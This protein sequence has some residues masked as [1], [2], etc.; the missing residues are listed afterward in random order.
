M[1]H[2]IPLVSGLDRV[3]TRYRHFG[4]FLASAIS[5]FFATFGDKGQLAVITL[6]SV[7]DAKRVFAGAVT[8][9]AIWN[10]IEVTIGAAIVRAAP[11]ATLEYVTGGLFLVFGLWAAYE[12]YGL[13][14]NSQRESDEAAMLDSVLPD[15]IRDRLRGAGPFVIAFATIAVAEV[16]DKTQLLTIDLSATFPGSPVA[17]FAGAWI[18]LAVR[19]GLDAFVGETAERYLPTA[20]M[21]GAAAAVF[22]AGGLFELGVL[23]GLAV[24]GVAAAAVVFAVG[25]ALYRRVEHPADV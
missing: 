25:G 2:V 4:P 10:A 11:A 17:V 7:Y 24:V 3:V 19:T 12:A 22:V 8:A 21:Q 20:F 5:N 1:D 6:A 13:Y 14:R 15:S 9:F 16:G 18:G 23:P